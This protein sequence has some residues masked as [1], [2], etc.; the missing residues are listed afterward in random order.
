L[1]HDLLRLQSLRHHDQRP[2]RQQLPQQRREERLRRLRH[3][4][5]SPCAALLHALPEGL[6]GGSSYDGGEYAWVRR[7]G[8]GWYQAWES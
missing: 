4:A 5:A 1:L 6:R 2:A 7:A 3:A 8:F